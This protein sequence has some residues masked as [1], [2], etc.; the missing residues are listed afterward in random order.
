MA[1]QID[2][3]SLA[4]A[5]RALTGTARDGWRTIAIG[6]S[7]TAKLLAGR[8]MPGNE[9]AVLVGFRSADILPTAQLPQ[10]RGF[11]LTRVD[12]DLDGSGCHWL[13]ISRQSGGRIELFSMMVADLIGSLATAGATDQT[14][15]A[16]VFLARVRAWQDFMQRGDEGVLGAEAEVGLV[17]ELQMLTN[18]LDLGVAAGLAASAWQGPLH[19]LRDFSLGAGA[20]E[21][22]STLATDGFPA[23]I[24]SLEQL[25]DAAV[26][27]L[28]VAA[29]RLHSGAGSTLPTR[30]A[31]LRTRMAGDLSA[32]AL[33]ENAL[34]HAGYAQRMAE[35]YTRQF[36]HLNTRLMQ[37][38]GSFPRLTQATVPPQIRRAQYVI[39]LDSVGAAP[40]PLAAVLSQLG[41][42]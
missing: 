3:E 20:I 31:D 22:K 27:P 6:T 26:S 42:I 5:W 38:T 35:R 2:G 10:G 33:F 40:L 24:G 37:V 13:G 36:A 4:A 1:R 17:G 16:G 34:L 29:V 23:F 8:R 7:G 18:L 41:V 11:T 30:V 21:V 12:L 9:E 14:G 15:L 25:D 19:G 39:D 28:F 32:C